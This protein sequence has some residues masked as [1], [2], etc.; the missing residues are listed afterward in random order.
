[1]TTRN[2]SAGHPWRTYILASIPGWAIAGVVA[3][4]LHRTAAMP[5]W[6]AVVIVAAW[7]LTDLAMFPRMRRY[8]SSEPSERRMIGEEG[9]AV[10]D[11]APR[12]FVRV[13]GE[14]WQAC[15]RESGPAI[16]EGD[17]VRVRD[18]SGLELT[19]ERPWS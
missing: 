2:T 19:V 13:H 8:Y 4:L 18:I 7:V 15:V 16:R 14:L 1:M 17:A 10:S 5:W 6:A 12:G 3:L 11:V 9:V